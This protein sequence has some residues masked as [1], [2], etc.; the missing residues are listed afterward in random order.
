M[1]LVD[2]RNEDSKIGAAGR[3]ERFE[4]PGADFEAAGAVEGRA[5][6]IS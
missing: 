5:L 1:K 2:L 3:A 6:V 4:N